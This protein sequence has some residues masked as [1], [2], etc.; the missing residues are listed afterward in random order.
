MARLA[1]LA[2]TFPFMGLLLMAC[3]QTASLTPAAS[4]DQS[5]QGKATRTE[6]FAQFKD[7]PIPGVAEMDME[8]TII[9]GSQDAWTGRVHLRVNMSAT[10]LFE[11]YKLEMSGFGWQEVTSV[12]AIISV[13]TYER[14]SRV[15]TIQILSNKIKGT[16]VTITVS[17]KDG[18]S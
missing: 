13:L 15:A 18:K 12:R 9:L 2:I 17:P 1:N 16:V 6:P 3:G 10:K 11:F 7:I 14:D 8:R 4:P 5:S